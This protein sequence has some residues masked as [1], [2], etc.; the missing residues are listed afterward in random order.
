MMSVASAALG[1]PCVPGYDLIERIGQGGMGEVFRAR[2]AA[3]GRMVAIKILIPSS[4]EDA[5]VCVMRFRREAELMARA[6]HPH[7]VAMLDAG[8]SAGRP[9]LV[10]EFISGGDLRRLLKPGQ[11]LPLDQA[12]PI[13]KAVADALQCLHQQGILHRDLKPENILL[14]G[15][16]PKLA[17]FGI[18]VEETHVGQLTRASQA[19]GT[20]G[21]AAPEQHY[22]LPID[23]RADQFAL[24]SVAYEMLTGHKPLGAFK[25]PSEHNRHLSSKVDAVLLRALQEDRNDRYPD[26]GQ[27]TRA[28]DAALAQGTG[29]NNRRAVLTAACAGIAGLG[30]AVGASPFLWMLLQGNKG[31]EPLPT[32]TN[33]LGMQLVLIPP[34]EFLKGATPDDL[35]ADDSERPQRLVQIANSYYL[36]AHEVTVGQFQAFV[37]A[38]GYQTEAEKEGGG[39]WDDVSR[40]IRFD[41]EVHWRLPNWGRPAELDHPVTQVRWNDAVAFCEWLSA[42]EGVL[43]RLPTE[44]EWEYACRAGRTTRWCCGE[45][46]GSLVDVAW[47]DANSHSQVQPVGRKKPNRWGLY[48]MHGNV[49]EWCQGSPPAQVGQAKK[50]CCGGSF[51]NG[52]MECRA[53]YR[54]CMP[55]S[56]RYFTIGFRVCRM[57]GP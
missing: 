41:P 26:V 56:Y 25:R 27:F 4:L 33:S 1:F 57:A 31:S 40:S 50:P 18:A 39:Y 23:E 38:T 24:A 34:G 52:P 7:I 36:G 8:T 20:P 22:R 55:P 42:L 51:E 32:I 21:Y 10:T 43:Y 2:Q 14:D 47:Y 19:I 13:L 49:C 6:A 48:D 35:D 46:L 16:T 29:R 3:T 30:L 11:P 15:E 17:D 5:A 45:D 54:D 9:Y 12:R 53:S 28:L 44:T 37:Q